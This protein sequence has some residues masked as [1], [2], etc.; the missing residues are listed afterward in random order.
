MKF[1]KFDAMMIS[2]NDGDGD[3]NNDSKAKVSSSRSLDDK[4]R[5]LQKKEEEK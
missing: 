4:Q 3:D 1:E 5:K 2:I